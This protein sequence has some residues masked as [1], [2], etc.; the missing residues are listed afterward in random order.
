LPGIE[1]YGDTIP[2]CKV[3]GDHIT[4]VDFNKRYNLDARIAKAIKEGRTKQ[5]ANLLCNKERSGI[6]IIDAAG[7]SD[8]ANVVALT[9]HQMLLLG[10][11]YE[12][13]M[14]GEITKLLFEEIN[15][16]CYNSFSMSHHSTMIYGEIAT[17]GKFRFILAGHPPPLVFSNEYNRFVE[18][19]KDRLVTLPIIGLSPYK[20]DIDNDKTKKPIGYKKKYYVNEIDLMS[21][22]DILFLYTDGITEHNHKEEFYYP[23]KME[24]KVRETKHLHPKEMYNQ[25]MYDINLFGK[26]E[27]DMTLVIVKKT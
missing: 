4:W 22:G 20:E 15:M 13:R 19:P 9:L 12:L 1:V 7:H 2:L 23:K 24:Q 6:L 5:A 25:I 21:P 17:N 26:P 18:I 27:D 10:V 16:R 8:S 14:H 3:G 11:R